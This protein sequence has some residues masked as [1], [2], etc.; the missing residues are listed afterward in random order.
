MGGFG[1]VVVVSIGVIFVYSGVAKLRTGRFSSDLSAYRLVPGA[2]VRPLA[3][4]LPWVELVVGLVLCFGV[5]TTP[6]LWIAVSL[7]TLFSGAMVVNLARGRR[8]SC[9]CQ[10]SSRPISLPLVVRNLALIGLT[11]VAAEL[12]APVP[13]LRGLAGSPALSASSAGALFAALILA[14][15]G[16]RLVGAT[17]QIHRRIRDAGVPAL[18]GGTP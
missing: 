16:A 3:A 10:G 8:V 14:A 13:G 7:L 15:V 4:V 1:F 12:A 2:A 5:G 11:V 9:G 6:A 18:L 17:S